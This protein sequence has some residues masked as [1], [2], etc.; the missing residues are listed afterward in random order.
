MTPST[1]EAIRVLIVD[2]H[3]VVRR[4][5][6]VIVAT[7]PGMAVAG[8]ASNGAE[9][10]A[11]AAELAP[12]VILMDLMMPVMDGIEAI[13]EIRAANPEARVLVLTSFAEG[14][15]IFPAIRAG[16][17][18]YLLKD[19]SPEEL[20]AAIR[21]VYQGE[22]RL[23]SEVARKLMMGLSTHDAPQPPAESL[24]DREVDVLKL[25][26][27]GLSNRRIAEELVISEGTVHTHVRNIL[28][29]LDLSNRTQAALYALRTGLSRLHDS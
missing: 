25:V 7:E 21:D 2:D 8:T 24:T 12:D 5:L 6:Q 3:A 20:T 9:A 10:V 16:A 18:G 14:E 15:Q 11:R 26:A 4:G 1:D 19:S 13:G 29:K 23:D 27:R 22:P 28:T 17:L